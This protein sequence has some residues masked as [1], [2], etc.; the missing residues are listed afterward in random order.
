MAVAPPR[1]EARR[2]RICGNSC[3]HRR[4]SRRGGGWL[5]RSSRSKL[6]QNSAAGRSARLRRRRSST[7][8]LGRCS[9]SGMGSVAEILAEFA[10]QELLGVV[11]T[12][13]DGA[14]GAVHDFGDFGVA[15]A[16]Y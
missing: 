10:L 2:A 3:H 5:W 9:S 8:T 1:R 7:V 14:F 16:V 13:A 12:R 4:P 15:E 6:V 11:K